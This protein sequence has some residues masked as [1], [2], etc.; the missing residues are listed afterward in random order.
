[1]KKAPTDSSTNCSFPGCG[2]KSYSKSLCWTH[3]RQSRAT[4]KLRPIGWRTENARFK[5]K[6]ASE[7]RWWN[8]HRSELP[9][10][11]HDFQAFVAEVGPKPA[12]WSTVKEVDGRFKWGPAS[13]PSLI[14]HAGKSLSL[15]EWATKLGISRQGLF[16][17]IKRHGPAKALSGGRQ[18]W[19][20][21]RAV[22]AVLD[23]R[24]PAEVAE[25]YHVTEAQVL[26]AVKKTGKSP[27]RI[28]PKIRRPFADLLARPKAK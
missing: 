9:K 20:M 14:E 10:R 22:K 8:R 2:R 19:L 11:L 4:G 3:Y 15:A 23:G 5:K 7:F 16:Y 6:Y 27:R 17:R 21:D 12:R 1:M 24:D 25:A 26:A 28:G 18:V 13:R